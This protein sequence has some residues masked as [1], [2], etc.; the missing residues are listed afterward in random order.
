MILHRNVAAVVDHKPIDLQISCIG[1][2]PRINTD[3]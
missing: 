2:N 1:F 3:S